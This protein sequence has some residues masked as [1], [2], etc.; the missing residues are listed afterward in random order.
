MPK[1]QANKPPSKFKA[2]YAAL[3]SNT[4]SLI[5]LLVVAIVLIALGLVFH[6]NTDQSIPSTERFFEQRKNVQE[7][8]EYQQEDESAKKRAEKNIFLQN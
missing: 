6:F 4:Q 2:K 5:K 8:H 3:N 7:Y 1:S